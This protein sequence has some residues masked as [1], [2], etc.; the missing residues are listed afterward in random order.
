MEVGPRVADIYAGRSVLVTGAT[1]FLGKV[2]IEKLLFSVT[3]IKNVYLLMRT[4]NGLGPK[5]RMEK[6]L[7]GPLFNRLRQC[8]PGAFSKLISVS[9][10]IMEEGLGLNQLDMQTICDEVSIVFHCAATVKFD[11]ALRISIEM[12]VLGTQR[13]VALCHMI[14][15]LLVF[16][17]VSTAYA[18][19]DKSEITETIYPP[20]VPPNKLFDAIDWMDDVMIDAVTPYLLG[21]RPNT[22]TFTKALA[23]VQLAEDGRQLPL[24]IIRP[25]IIG[26]MWREPL[27]G[28]TDNINGPSGIFAA[29]GKGV[30]TNMCGSSCA[31]ADII[32]VDVVSNLMIVAAAH[33]ANNKYNEIPVIHC[34]SGDLNP[35]KWYFIVN[36]IQNFF[37]RFP[38]NDCY[39]VP[40][41]HFHASRF[42]YEL[43][44]FMKHIAPAYGVDVMNSILGRKFRLLRSYRK[45]FRLVETLHYFTMRGWNFDARGLV[46]LWNS[47]AEEDKEIFNFDI[48]QLDW[49]SYL[50][51]YLM[52]VKRY[53]V[54]DRLEE[55]PKARRNLSWLKLYSAAFS[56]MFWWLAVR[57][58]GRK[59]SR[60]NQWIVW[61]FGFLSTYIWSNYSFREPTRLKSLD[62]YKRTALCY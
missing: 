10:D 16:V 56:A 62:E 4:K 22:Y 55:L 52:G 58:C 35:V 28:W 60:K 45:V 43:N 3:S 51:D 41:T 47:T 40:S 38:L 32:P 42:L 20:P 13:L 21:Q 46:E 36:Y 19:C 39:R 61:S 2:L 9:G 33:R 17:H 30:L 57:L 8:N 54:G 14:K 34:S 50:F 7:E 15:N 12:N 25:S 49:N 26:A 6:L 23:E 18:N 37:R 5:Q 29:C 48:R 27:P 31:K 53:V 59:Y 11:E 24:I 1:G 44:N